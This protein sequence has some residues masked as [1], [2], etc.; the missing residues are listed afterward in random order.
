MSI[1]PQGYNIGD[2]PINENPFWEVEI[3]GVG[4]QSVQARKLEY[5]DRTEYVFIY[6]DT[7]GETHEIIRQVFDKEEG[8]VFIP[9]IEN[10]ILSW[11]NDAGLNNPAPVSIIGP[12]GERGPAGPTGATG[13]RGEIG[14]AGPKG[15][16][17]PQGIQGIQGPQGERGPQGEQGV[18]GP[19]GPIGP[20]GPRGA[21]GL[22]GDAPGISVDPIDNGYRITIN[23][24][25]NVEE[26]DL[27]NGE[28]GPAGP[29]G[30]KGDAGPQG[31]QGEVGPAGPQGIQGVAGPQGI[32]GEKGATGDI[33]P[34]GPKG[35]K[36]DPGPQGEKGAAAFTVR[37][38]TVTQG[39]VANVINSGTESDL[40]LDFTIPKGDKG[41]TGAMG[42][43]GP[44]GSNGSN[45]EAA[46]IIPGTV[47]MLGY[48]EQPYVTNSGTRQNAIF[49]FG[50]PQAVELEGDGTLYVAGRGVG[51]F[52]S[53]AKT[54][55]CAVEG[56]NRSLGDLNFKVGD[57]VWLVMQFENH[58]NKS[59]TINIKLADETNYMSLANS[60]TYSITIP[61]YDTDDDGY[62]TVTIPYLLNKAVSYAES[63]TQRPLPVFNYDV[64]S[65]TSDV[66]MNNLSCKC[67]QMIYGYRGLRGEKGERGAQGIQGVAGPQGVPGEPGPQG[68]RGETALTVSVGAVETLPAGSDPYVVNNGTNQDIILDFGLPAG[69]KGD[70]G[71][72]GSNGANGV[73]PEITAT[74]SVT[75]EGSAG[76]SVTRSGT[77]ANPN[78]DFA[79]TGI[80]G[81]S[82]GGSDEFII[83]QVDYLPINRT[84]D[85]VGQ[86]VTA[87]FNIEFSS[88]PE[89]GYLPIYCIGQIKKAPKYQITDNAFTSVGSGLGGSVSAAINIKNTNWKAVANNYSIDCPAIWVLRKFTSLSEY[90]NYF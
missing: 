56:V 34:T 19:Q 50:I 57:A 66:T 49:N 90:V 22:P 38:G 63:A 16:Q 15:D 75:S 88:L 81:G 47:T 2:A 58:N 17:G 69:A 31:I 24:D 78:F 10:G 29:K 68:E 42:P 51:T 72:P 37:V 21:D 32:Q 39:S 62:V 89:D 65:V 86:N 46:T 9:S 12:A 25:G 20:A 82:G 27:H 33:G 60:D 28:T 74:A 44:A 4:V 85:Q 14:P 67:S 41:D 55:S 7:E 71:D 73:T 61:P 8:A 13:Q 52:N 43:A 45:G 6:I 53:V 3:T 76:V 84:G 48:N 40:V 83:R 36:G 70:K 79:F 35:D 11:T 18:P 87:L 30:E 1:S 80:G 23:S 5:D 26:F 54:L 77:D 59:M 64:T